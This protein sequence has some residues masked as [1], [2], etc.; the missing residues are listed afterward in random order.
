[1]SIAY[2]VISM[3]VY[4]LK[5]T[6]LP[7]TYKIFSSRKIIAKIPKT[8]PALHIFMSNEMV[9]IATPHNSTSQRLMATLMVNLFFIIILYGII[10]FMSHQNVLC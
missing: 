10:P 2:L 7:D 9:F 4:S 1:M 6:I 3:L 8:H 5:L